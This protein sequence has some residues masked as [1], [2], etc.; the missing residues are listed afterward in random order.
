LI[1]DGEQD[2]FEG[3]R[4]TRMNPPIKDLEEIREKKRRTRKKKPSSRGK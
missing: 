2:G 4:E 1:G 3:E